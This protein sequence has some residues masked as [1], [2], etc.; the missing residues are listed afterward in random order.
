[1]KSEDTFH[2]VKVCTTGEDFS[3]EVK[4]SELV[5]SIDAEHPGKAR[6]RVALD[7][8]QIQG[9]NGSHQCLV[10]APL[11]LTYTKFRTL[12]PNNALNKDLLQQSLLMIL[13][14]LD[15]LHQAGIVHTGT[16]LSSISELVETETFY[17]YIAKQHSP[18]SGRRQHFFKDRTER[19][20]KSITAQ[21]PR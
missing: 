15:F 5:R 17:R 16:A 13:L 2:T 10:F 8:F 21:G 1:M 9:P 14:G 20:A 4:V 19:T 11:G 18:W 7:T 6:L 12:F 3:N